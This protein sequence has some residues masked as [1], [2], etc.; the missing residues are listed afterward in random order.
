MWNWMMSEREVRGKIDPDT[1]ELFR[2][3]E[4]FAI[5]AGTNEP[6]ETLHKIDAASVKFAG[7]FNNTAASNKRYL[8]DVFE[9]GDLWFRSGDVMRVDSA[10]RVFFVDR[11]GDT[12]RWKSENVST[13]EVAD[14]LSGFEQIDECAVYGVTIPH[15]DGRC[16]CATIVTSKAI[17][18]DLSDFNFRELARYLIERLPRYAVPV[19]LRIV[20]ELSYTGNYK[21]QKA[22]AKKEGVDLSAITQAGSKE[23]MYWIPPGSQSYVPYRAEDWAALRSGQ[24]KL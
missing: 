14:V 9:Q 20:P 6:G 21:I 11:L 24:V 12:F 18:A 19:F 23:Q 8:K 22:E 7:Y 3:E 10:G 17:S 15:A 1:E 13:T 2:N 5:R 4:G 16:G